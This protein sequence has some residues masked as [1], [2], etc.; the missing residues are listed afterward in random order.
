MTL[1][2]KLVDQE[3][4]RTSQNN[5]LVSIW[6]PTSFTEQRRGGVEEAKTIIL[7]I[8]HG[9]VSLREGVC[10]SLQAEGQ[11]SMRQVVMYDYKNKRNEK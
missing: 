5:H 3:D 4:D 6:M 1:F 8:T 2:G 10:E 9:M 7:Q 11:G